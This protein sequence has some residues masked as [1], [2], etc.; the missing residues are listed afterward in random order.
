[1]Y[2]LNSHQKKINFNLLHVVIISGVL[3]GTSDAGSGDYG[4]RYI[5]DSRITD[6]DSFD[7]D[8]SDYDVF[9]EEVGCRHI[10]ELNRNG[11]DVWSFMCIQLCL[12]TAPKI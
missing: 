7:I 8:D 9:I 6:D 5:T 2:P 10:P 3:T 1:M 12:Q 11:A 4:Q